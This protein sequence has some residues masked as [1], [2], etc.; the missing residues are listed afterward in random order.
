[1][2][3]LN[4]IE[5]LQA[6]NF[7]KNQALEEIYHRYSA[8]VYGVC[9]KYLGS[10]DDSLDSVVEIFHI[11]PQKITQHKIENF[12]SWLYSVTKNHCLMKL[13]SE[14]RQTEAMKKY[15]YLNIR[16]T[17]DV[18][19]EITTSEKIEN[20]ICQ[21]SSEQKTC[22][23]LFYY[24]KKSYSEISDITGYTIK[25]VKSFLQNGRIKLKKIMEENNNDE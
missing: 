25:A 5:V 3:N 10:R 19:E 17:H 9:L 12:S 23:E 1:M 22:V 11:L 13:R 21:L 6:F 15:A 4:D 24:Q 18:E 16:T 7:N 8:L 14:K 2:K 20:G